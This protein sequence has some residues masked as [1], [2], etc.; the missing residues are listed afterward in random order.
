MKHLAYI[1]GGSNLGNRKE[2]IERAVAEL[3]K[4]AGTV[5]KVSSFYETE[6]VGFLDQPWF[7]NVVIELETN[8]RPE[9]LLRAC[10]EIETAGGRTRSFAN[11]PRTLDLDILLYDDLVLATPSLVIPHPRITERRFVLEPLAE[12]APGAVHPV[13]GQTIRELFRACPDNSKI[14]KK[15]GRH[16]ISDIAE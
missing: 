1:S 13:R 16:P 5:R 8:L 14:F 9:D 4:T 10:Q 15:W 3:G 6:P 2:Q 11:A 7:L 12:I